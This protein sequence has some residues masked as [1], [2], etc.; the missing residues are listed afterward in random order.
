M[1][2]MTSPAFMAFM[3]SGNAATSLLVD[4]GMCASQSPNRFPTLSYLA[5]QWAF[6][7]GVFGLPL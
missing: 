6:H 5:F 7:A 4:P 2:Y 1:L 3:P